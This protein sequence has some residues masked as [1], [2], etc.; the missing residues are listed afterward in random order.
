LTEK[1]AKLSLEN[2][3]LGKE[4][5]N[6]RKQFDEVFE[7]CGFNSNEDQGNFT[8]DWKSRVVLGFKQFFDQSFEDMKKELF[9]SQNVEKKTFDVLNILMR[10]GHPVEKIL[11]SFENSETLERWRYFNKY[12]VLKPYQKFADFIMNMSC[13]TSELITFGGERNVDLQSS[14]MNIVLV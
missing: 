7:F 12:L 14:G 10:K 1:I 4:K 6:A 3:R 5:E 2:A 9:L 13:A 8:E 11:S